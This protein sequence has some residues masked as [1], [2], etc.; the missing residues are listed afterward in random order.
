MITSERE[1]HIVKLIR[2]G[3][4]I[5]DVSEETGLNYGDVANYLDSVDRTSWLGAKRIV[6]FCLRDLVNETD[7]EKRKELAERADFWADMLY[8]D[9]K[10]VGEM[11]E[12]ALKTMENARDS[13]DR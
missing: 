2:R 5:A 3:K 12:Q 4:T 7:P 11:L 10:R 6:S 8:Y 1:K 13:L 9:A